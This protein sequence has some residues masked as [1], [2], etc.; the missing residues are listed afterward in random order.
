MAAKK[1]GVDGFAPAYWLSLTFGQVLFVCEDEDDGVPHLPIVDDP[2]QLL[3]G[4]VDTVSV[5]AV[6]HE[7]Q[8][9]S[10]GVVM[11]PKGPDLVLAAHVLHRQRYR[12]RIG[13]V[14]RRDLPRH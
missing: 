5:G 11:P 4:L 7:D 13:A 3:P 14:W 10:A 9:L 12:A 2:V 8:A 6:H 1:D